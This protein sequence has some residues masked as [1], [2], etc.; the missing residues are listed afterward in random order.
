M[1]YTISDQCIGCENCL[2]HCPTGAI[3]KKENGKFAINAN[4][5]NDCVDYYGVA[6]CMAG[7]PTSNGCTP[8]ISTLI[9]SAQLTTNNYWDNWFA[10]Y[11]RLTSRLKAKHETK[12]WQHW[13]NSYSEKLEHLLVSH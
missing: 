2:P 11:A 4:L 5:C 3:E 6:Q 8:T 9:K 7:C 1:T 10:T 13:F 12:Y